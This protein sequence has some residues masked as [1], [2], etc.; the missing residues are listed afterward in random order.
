MGISPLQH[1]GLTTSLKISPINSQQMVTDHLSAAEMT[2]AAACP[3]HDMSVRVI[4]M[5]WKDFKM[6]IAVEVLKQ[7][8]YLKKICYHSIRYILMNIP[9]HIDI[10]K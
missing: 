6:D 10:G 4:L 9:A 2:S 7:Y 3:N 8:E 5:R 1:V